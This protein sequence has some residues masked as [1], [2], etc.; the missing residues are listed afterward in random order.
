MTRV[1][2]LQLWVNWQ[3]TLIRAFEAQERGETEV[4]CPLFCGGEERCDCGGFQ[5]VPVE[6]AK[7]LCRSMLEDL[8][9]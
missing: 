6:Q 7:A 1:Q 3:A 9:K 5:R 8:D 2:I 4:P